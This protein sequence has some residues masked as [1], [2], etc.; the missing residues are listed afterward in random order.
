MKENCLK[1]NNT[2]LFLT[3]SAFF[4]VRTA[5]L[6][7]V[8][9]FLMKADYPY[10]RFSAGGVAYIVLAVALSI[11][12][13]RLAFVF[14][15]KL[16][17]IAAVIYII[18]MSDPLFFGTKSDAFRLLTDIIINLLVLNVINEKKRFP[19]GVMLPVSLLIITFLV[20]FSILGYVPV[21]L[22]I[23]ILASRKAKKESKG[24]RVV[25]I[26]TACAI[27]G[28]LLNKIV[29]SLSEAFDEW[30]TAFTFADITETT[31]TIRFAASLLPLVVF[32][33]AF[34]WQY[35]KAIAAS[36]AKRSEKNK[37]FETALDAFFIPAVISLVSI[38]F[39][40]AEG[41]CAL[42]IFVPAI[43]LTLLYY[44]DEACIRTIDRFV[45][46]IKENKILSFVI[47]VAIFALALKGAEDYFPARQ[48]MFYIIY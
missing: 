16:G 7:P 17:E 25:L 15:D 23:Y 6:A 3:L 10:F 36:S 31:K 2:G 47:F 27:A 20:P 40:G 46:L 44:K 14:R 37:N 11:L 19:V 29:M 13:A 34:F 22:S 45:C 8:H 26:A 39:T 9:C 41:F 1:K 21:I 18:A 12:S 43:V 28:F 32:G 5:L 4:F 42:N 33:T 38:F 24:V 35:K 48:L 30:F